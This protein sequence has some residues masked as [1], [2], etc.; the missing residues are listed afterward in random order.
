M[1]SR[2]SGMTLIEVII[3][4]GLVALFGVMA[5]PITTGIIDS[6]RNNRA[7][8]DIGAAA[9]KIYSWH[10]QYGDYPDSL[11]EAGIDMPTDPWGRPYIYVRIASSE[12]ESAVRGTP[13]ES[14]TGV[15]T[16]FDLFSMGRDGRTASRFSSDGSRDDV[17][18]AGNGAYVGLASKL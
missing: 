16:D 7:I 15:N 2:A 9:F 17:I 8:G 5:V 12:N 1:K 3:I 4:L 11:D 14:H 6:A 18:R 13:H 10:K